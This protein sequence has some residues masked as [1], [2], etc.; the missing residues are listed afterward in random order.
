MCRLTLRETELLKVLCA[1]D[2]RLRP[3]LFTVLHWAKLMELCGP[4]VRLTSYALTLL[5]IFYMQNTRPPVLP[6]I[7]HLSHIAGN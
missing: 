5:V 7:Q 3:L 2:Y 4:G 1:M 6:S